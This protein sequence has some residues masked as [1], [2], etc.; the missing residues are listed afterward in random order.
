MRRLILLKQQAL[1]APAEGVKPTFQTTYLPC[2]FQYSNR[3]EGGGGED[4]DYLHALQSVV[5][6]GTMIIDHADGSALC[7]KDNIYNT[8]MGLVRVYMNMLCAQTW[9]IDA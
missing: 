3:T 1:P 7:R 8:P 5:V 4:E 6:M 2:R 9:P